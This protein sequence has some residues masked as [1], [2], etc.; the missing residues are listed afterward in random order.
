MLVRYIYNSLA[1]A[2][3]DQLDLAFCV[4][5]L[6]LKMQSLDSLNVSQSVKNSSEEKRSWTFSQ[7]Y[8][9]KWVVEIDYRRIT[10]LKTFGEGGGWWGILIFF[11]LKKMLDETAFID[12]SLLKLLYTI[13]HD[14]LEWRLRFVEWLSA[15]AVLLTALKLWWM[16]D[17]SVCF[18]KKTQQILGLN[19]NSTIFQHLTV[20]SRKFNTL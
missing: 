15:Q 10:L 18:D 3:T 11:S 6:L 4:L 14:W 2:S 1:W 16:E 12:F 19:I 5:K 9:D 20:G 7:I 13:K 17:K 8:Q